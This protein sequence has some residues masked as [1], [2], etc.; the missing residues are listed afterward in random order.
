[1]ESSTEGAQMATMHDG[2][3]PHFVLAARAILH[4]QFPNKWIGCQGPTQ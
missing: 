2:A 3:P 4:Q 1:M